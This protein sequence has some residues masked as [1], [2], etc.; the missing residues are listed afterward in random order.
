MRRAVLWG[1]AAVF[2]LAGIATAAGIRILQAGHDHSQAPPGQAMN[3]AAPEAAD[4]NILAAPFADLDGK[5]RT[6]EN[7]GPVVLNF[8]ATWCAPCRAE[9]P[10]LDSAAAGTTVPLLG[11]SVAD[12]PGAVRAFLAEVPVKYEILTA[13]FDIF[14]FFQKNGNTVGA[15]PFTV[16]LDEN[17]KVLR[18]KTGEFHS[19]DEFQK[20]AEI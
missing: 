18:T 11:I 7:S 8:W 6:L 2:V 15:M 17:G 12:P 13:K 4:F 3:H 19:E 20:F 16:L 1:F 9:M 10:L 14:Y 5:I